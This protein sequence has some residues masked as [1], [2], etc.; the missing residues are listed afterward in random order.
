[1][2]QKLKLVS[3]TGVDNQTKIDELNQFGKFYP[4][5]EWAMLYVP[6][7]EG[8]PRNPTAS[9]RNQFINS[10]SYGHVA[11]HLCGDKAF[12]QLMDGSLPDDLTCVNR[13]QLNINARLK[14]FTDDEVVDVYHRALR[15]G[16]SIILQ[17]N[18]VTAEAVKR[19][20]SEVNETH[21]E[22]VHIL[23]DESRGKGVCP[24]SWAI[25]QEFEGMFCGF[26][27]GINPNNVIS[28]LE[29]VDA[30]GIDYWIDM[31]S[32]IREDNQFSIKKA[33]AILKFSRAFTK[34]KEQV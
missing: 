3:L 25:P 34:H 28:V 17:Y 6:H 8:A 2:N 20:L 24:E 1:M 30:L 29:Q 13:L 31:E 21:R 32:G 15:L 11:A 12:H 9:W 23:L 22:R 14:T 33:H 5:V 16:P 26:A 19:F 10:W 27:G 7:N 4:Y 18:Q